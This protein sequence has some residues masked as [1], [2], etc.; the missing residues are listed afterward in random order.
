M[1]GKCTKHWQSSDVFTFVLLG[2]YKN[3]MEGW[4]NLYI[5]VSA[6]C[7]KNYPLLLLPL[8][9]SLPRVIVEIAIA[10]ADNE[11][12]THCFQCLIHNILQTNSTVMLNYVI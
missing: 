9:Q 7:A 6:L 4:G 2:G 3:K 10:F 11:Q 12:F 1:A 8:L 5:H